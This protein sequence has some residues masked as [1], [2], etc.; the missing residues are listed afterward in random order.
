MMAGGTPASLMVLWAAAVK[1]PRLGFDAV[2]GVLVPLVVAALSILGAAMTY[3]RQQQDRYRDHLRGLFSEALRAVADYQEVP[4]LVRRRG[5]AS[6]MT[7]AELVRHTGDVQ[8]RLDFYTA[9]L[10]LESEHLGRAYERLIRAVRQES[11]PHISEAWRQPRLASDGQMPLGAAY[12][13]DLADTQREECLRVMREYVAGAGGLD[14][15]LP[16]RKGRQ[17]TRR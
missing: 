1:V 16:W 15:P 9:R 14:L 12:P 8:S 4:Y 5:D 6:P 7:A 10:Q 17:P 13:R 3:R 11:G 2:V